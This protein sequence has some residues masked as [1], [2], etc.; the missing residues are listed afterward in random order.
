LIAGGD[1][2]SVVIMQGS[3][4]PHIVHNACCTAIDLDETHLAEGFA[5]GVINLR[6]LQ[7]KRIVVPGY[8]GLVGRVTKI[9]LS[10]QLVCGQTQE[11][12]LRV[13]DRES[14]TCVFEMAEVA[15][16]VLHNDML[17]VNAFPGRTSV[18]ANWNGTFL[19]VRNF[20]SS[21]YE[22]GLVTDGVR[23]FAACSLSFG[24]HL[25]ETRDLVSGECLDY[26]N[27]ESRGRIAMFQAMP[28]GFA[29]GVGHGELWLC[30]SSTASE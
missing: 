8:R 26:L 18:W 4:A 13:W 30:T 17:I 11:D 12:H 20:A 14:G 15:S 10:E 23:L 2:H 22:K 7:T 25:V 27:I 24:H 1:G 5:N 3:A 29:L 9:T 16:Y 6:D 21:V 28:D 19:Q